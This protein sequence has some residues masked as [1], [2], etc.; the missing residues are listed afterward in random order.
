MSAQPRRPL[1]GL[2][3]AVLK[4]LESRDEEDIVRRAG[5]DLQ[6]A[7][8]L[9]ERCLNVADAA[10][11]SVTVLVHSPEFQPAW[12]FELVGFVRPPRVEGRPEQTR[13]GTPANPLLER[14]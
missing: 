4:E 7:A 13:Q 2:P 14:Q 3:P 9:L 11:Y 5:E 8:D 1:G 12:S 10:G 6:A